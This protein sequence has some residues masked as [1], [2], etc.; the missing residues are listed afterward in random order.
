MLHHGLYI[1]AAPQ[2]KFLLPGTTLLSLTVQMFKDDG[3]GIIEY[4][5]IYDEAGSF[6]S[7]IIVDA[8]R[9]GPE[10]GCLEITMLL[11]LPDASESRILW[12]AYRNVCLGSCHP[13]A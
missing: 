1:L 8:F 5:G 3:I 9:S 12:A 13:D 2:M 7:N 10:S 6:D 11:S 4:C